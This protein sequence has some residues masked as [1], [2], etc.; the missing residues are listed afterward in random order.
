[1]DHR[2]MKK[3]ARSGFEAALKKELLM[4]LDVYILHLEL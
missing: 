4:R 2:R 1:M 3:R